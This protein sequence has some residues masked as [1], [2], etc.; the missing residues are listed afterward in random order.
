MTRV[1]G[2]S[3]GWWPPPPGVQGIHTPRRCP[4]RLVPYGV[5]PSPGPRRFDV[6]RAFVVLGLTVGCTACSNLVDRSDELN[7]IVLPAELAAQV[8][9]DGDPYEWAQSE[10]MPV[11]F[12]PGAEISAVVRVQC[13]NERELHRFACDATVSSAGNIE[14]DL[15]VIGRDENGSCPGPLLRSCDIGPLEAGSYTLTWSGQTMTFDVPGEALPADLVV[16]SF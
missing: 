7:I 11:A 3:A 8:L 15:E 9:D 13:T 5:L 14:L 6:R 2:R 1:S 4:L 10:S 16:P 12:A